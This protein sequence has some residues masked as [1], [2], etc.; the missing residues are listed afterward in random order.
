MR[1]GSDKFLNKLVIVIQI[2]QNVRG[3]AQG[4]DSLM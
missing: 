1:S 2:D 3:N 4:K